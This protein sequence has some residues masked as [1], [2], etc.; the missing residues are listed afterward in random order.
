MQ[1]SITCAP[2]LGPKGLAGLI[3]GWE[4]I[5]VGCVVVI[6]MEPTPLLTVSRAA[7]LRWLARIGAEQRKSH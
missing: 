7:E 6:I 3:T 4:Y 2:G 5:I 1:T